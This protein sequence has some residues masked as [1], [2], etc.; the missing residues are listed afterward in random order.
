MADSGLLLAL[1]QGEQ[2][3]WALRRALL[4]NAEPFATPTTCV[5]EVWRGGTGP[6]T[7]TARALKGVREV[8]ID[9]VLARRAGVLLAAIGHDDPV[10]ALLVACAERHNA[11]VVTGDPDVRALAQHAGVAC[12]SL[13]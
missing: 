7:N 4:R 10:D 12:R 13:P 1:G 9:S 2:R 11:T 3:A 8:A 6:N 5:A